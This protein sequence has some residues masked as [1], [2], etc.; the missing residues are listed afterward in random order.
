MT[1]PMTLEELKEK[2]AS[3]IIV[4]CGSDSEY[5]CP[6]AHPTMGYEKCP[7]EDKDI[8]MWQLEQAEEQVQTFIQFCEENGAVIP[9]MEKIPNAPP[10]AFQYQS[11]LKPVSEVLK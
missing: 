1:K 2:I 5:P 10:D 4:D 6:H 7:H 11:K 3:R 8:C 9:V